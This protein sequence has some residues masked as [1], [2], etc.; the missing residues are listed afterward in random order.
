MNERV[1]HLSFDFDSEDPFSRSPYSQ[2]LKRIMDEEAQGLVQRAYQKTKELI[3]K[4]WN[5]VDIVSCHLFF[6]E[7]IVAKALCV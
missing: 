3:E 4:Y 2:N 1:G 6:H 7:G 5:Q